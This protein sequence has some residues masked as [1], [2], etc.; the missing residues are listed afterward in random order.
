MGTRLALRI[1]DDTIINS[2]MKASNDIRIVPPPLDVS[3]DSVHCNALTQSSAVSSAFSCHTTDSCCEDDGVDSSLALPLPH[4][5]C[6]SP[7]WVHLFSK[8]SS[9]TVKKDVTAS[10]ALSQGTHLSPQ[11]SWV[12]VFSKSCSTKSLRTQSIGWVLHNEY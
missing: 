12:H 7:S 4:S 5:N 3:S 2:I 11:P 6:P 1:K 8:S 10:T 9:T